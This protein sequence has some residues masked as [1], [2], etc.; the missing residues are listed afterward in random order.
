LTE[1][2]SPRRI[3]YNYIFLSIAIITRTFIIVRYF[4]LCSYFFTPRSQRFCR[5]YSVDLTIFFALKCILLTN[6]M[7]TIFI[8][9]CSIIFIGSYLVRIFERVLYLAPELYLNNFIQDIWFTI[10]AM[11][12]SI[13]FDNV[14]RIRRLRSSHPSW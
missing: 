13:P 7:K 4:I 1:T 10:I 3:K 2:I 14:S 5:I 9:F 6:P 12:T 8:F 11:T